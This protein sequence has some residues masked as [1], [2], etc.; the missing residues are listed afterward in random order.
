M[1]RRHY[2]WGKILISIIMAMMM[3]M[4]TALTAMGAVSKGTEEK[5]AEA[6]ITK[7]LVMPIGTNIPEIK[8]TFE[9]EK[10]SVDGK[11]ADKASM[12][13]IP[14]AQVSFS[15]TDAVAQ[16]NGIK[17]LNKETAN[18]FAD[19]NLTWNHAGIY[20]YRVTEKHDFSSTFADSMIMSNAVYE[21]DVYVDQGE[22]GLYVRY[23]AAYIKVTDEGKPADNEKVDPTPSWVMEKTDMSEMVFTNYYLKNNGGTDPDKTVMAIKKQVAGMSAD[24]S[25][26]FPFTIMATKPRT[27][28]AE[29]KYKAYLMDEKGV[30]SEITI[31]NKN[32]LNNVA[33]DGKND[34]FEL[35]SG[36]SLDVM[37]KHGQWLSFVDMPVGSMISA[38]ESAVA[39]YTPMF[40]LTLNG[41]TPIEING[42]QNMALGFPMTGT[43]SPVYIG[44]SKNSAVFTNTYKD[45]TP[46]G[47]S[48]DDLP[49][50][51]TIALVLAALAGFVVFKSRRRRSDN[52]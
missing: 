1:T 32:P 48:V 2:S 36:E 30:V 7:K 6:A 29:T 9:F 46:T 50:F 8:F 31:D 4:G 38:W 17:T 41:G 16:E 44:E 14:S 43:P 18:I 15:A 5:P 34:Y 21:I 40:E 25:M 24:Q 10:V 20:R 49:Y 39:D 37:L 33:N 3:C 42:F 51:V 11:P 22:E 12:P 19:Q 52:A 26:Y 13:E 47:I 45:I 23:I 35:K 27:V 28:T